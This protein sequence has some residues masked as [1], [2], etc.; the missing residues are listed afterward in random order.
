VWRLD[1]TENKNNLQTQKKSLC[2]H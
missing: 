1:Y 2:L